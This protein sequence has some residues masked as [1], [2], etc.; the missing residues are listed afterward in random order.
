[1]PICAIFRTKL[2]QDEEPEAVGWRVSNH[3]LLPQVKWTE[4]L[5]MMLHPN[6]DLE[7][8][9]PPERMTA[10]AS[11]ASAGHTWDLKLTK[12]HRAR[13]NSERACL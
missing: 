11:Q 13:E 6:T 9:V 4:A 12:C 8:W 3:K 2:G 7:M 5:L 10:M 1:M